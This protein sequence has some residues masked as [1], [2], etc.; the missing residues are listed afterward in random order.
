MKW[1]DHLRSCSR[2]SVA[3]RHR[4]AKIWSCLHANEHSA[5]S[6][7][8]GSNWQKHA[9]GPIWSNLNKRTFCLSVLSV[10]QPRWQPIPW[11]PRCP[12]WNA[13]TL[14]TST[15]PP[16]SPPHCEARTHRSINGSSDSRQPKFGRS[17]THS[18]FLQFTKS[19][20]KIFFFFYKCT[21]QCKVA[22][23]Y[24]VIPKWNG[25][26]TVIPEEALRF[27]LSCHDCIVKFLWRIHLVFDKL[28]NFQAKILHG[29][30]GFGQVGVDMVL[31]NSPAWVITY[32]L[33]IYYAMLQKTKKNHHSPES[34]SEPLPCGFLSTSKILG[35]WT[36]NCQASRSISLC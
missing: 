11:L 26:I 27:H 24:Q 16:K 17:I 5:S 23:T 25:T 18:S 13:Q 14:E 19:H 22:R 10:V 1:S 30:G 8:E 3:A 6:S 32:I 21:H 36:A 20:L 29:G 9:S 34:E 2:G 12:R 15:L 33:G 4:I 35:R 31:R 28:N 7:I